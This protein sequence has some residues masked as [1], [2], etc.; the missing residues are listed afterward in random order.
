M[1]DREQVAMMQED[2]AEQLPFPVD[3]FQAFTYCLVCGIRASEYRFCECCEVY[4]T[5]DPV[6]EL[7]LPVLAK[8]AMGI[9]QGLPGNGS[10]ST[11]TSTSIGMYFDDL[12]VQGN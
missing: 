11:S 8:T 2:L 9:F 6:R 4:V 12:A 1:V 3:Y 10:T 7:V 5:V